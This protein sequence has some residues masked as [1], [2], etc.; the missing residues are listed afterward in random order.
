MK[1]NKI[2]FAALASTMI[3]GCADED[4]MVNGNGS[5]Q[6]LNGKLVEAGLLSGVRDSEESSTR[7]Y[8][9]RGQFVWMPTELEDNG[10][11]TEARKNQKVGFCWTGNNSVHPEYAVTGNS[12]YVYTN[13]EYEHVGWLDVKAD[14][15]DDEECF[16]NELRNGAY[17]VG[18][19]SPEATWAESAPATFYNNYYTQGYPGTA[20]DP[21]GAY[22]QTTHA[23]SSGVLNLASGIFSTK[24]ASVFEGEYLV[25]YPY[26][27]AFTKG[28][29]VAQMP[30]EYDIVIEN[31]KDN[32]AGKYLQNPYAS[33]SDV[34]FAIGYLPHYEGGNTSSS[35]KA[36]TLNALVG[37]KIGSWDASDKTKQGA[38]VKIKTVML[39]SE[40]QGIMYQQNLNAG[41][42]I[43][44]LKNGKGVSAELFCGEPTKTNVIYAN[45]NSDTNE[46]ANE[47]NPVTVEGTKGVPAEY[48]TVAFPVFAQTVSDLQII[49]VN[50]KDQT[51]TVN[52]DAT[53]F[54]A[55]KAYMKTINL[56]GVKFQNEYMVVDEASLWSA[57][58]KIG[59]DGNSDLQAVNKIK[60]LNDITLEGLGKVSGKGNY[61]SWFFDKNINIYSKTTPI[62]TLTLA[63][64]QKMSIKGW[65]EASVNGEATLSFDVPV[66]IQGAGC[67]EKTPAVLVVG[68]ANEKDGK[69]VFNKD[70]TNY[71]TLALNN[72]GTNAQTIEI[73]GILTNK[74]DDY[75]V[76]KQKT[77]GAAEVYMMGAKDA[78]LVIGQFDNKNGKTIVAAT[79]VNLD[80]LFGEEAALPAILDAETATERENFVEIFT[81]NNDAEF[82]IHT[83]SMV[84]IGESFANSTDAVLK[85]Q[86]IAKSK[87]DGRIDIL[88]AAVNAG[89]I[90]NQGVSNLMT[91]LTNTGLFV[92]R[93]SGQV[94][95]KMI[96]NGTSEA[97]AEKKYGNMTYKTDIK[98][99]GIYVAQVETTDRM[100]KILSDK[101]IEPSVNIVEIV[102][103][104][105]V[106]YNMYQ[107]AD[108]MGDKDLLINYET[109][110]IKSYNTTDKKSQLRDLAHC[111]TVLDGCTLKV[112]DG[113]LIV[114]NN[115]NVEKDAVVLFAAANQADKSNIIVQGNINNDGTVTNNATYFEVKKNIENKGTFKSTTQFKV[116]KDV[117]NTGQFISKGDANLISGN[118]NQTGTSSYSEFASK[119]T[120]T[121][122]DTFTCTGGLFERL[123]V[124]GEEHRATVNVNT[125]GSVVG[126]KTTT[127]WPTEY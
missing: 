50:E 124:G 60:M 122:E 62:S 77:T 115:V 74:Y 49:L 4:F 126:G 53:I 52:A 107:Y 106:Y 55:N 47:Q 2:L 63:S 14:N 104:D 27:D 86:G 51:Y 94:G 99:A 108:A 71:G 45:L 24:N 59:S 88:G 113:R 69:V 70:V 85:T 35:F 42:C 37:V 117:N 118:F 9:S 5:A 40:T 97:G 41:K 93:Q 91:Q 1:K 110:V 3:V 11:L 34:A 111:V 90:D 13:Y 79:S 73:N 21:Q 112:F 72:N 10:A 48:V 100:N 16:D 31:D 33:A 127:A 105:V 44:A 114:K 26:T 119:T 8:T 12:S 66:V 19:G 38:D 18:E 109:I 30:T 82:D 46:Q 78:K 123:T 58:E 6:G 96:D 32:T 81:L 67:C 65:R 75:A 17:I 80:K 68:N 15:P 29:I 125:L 61:N 84:T 23:Q 28:E 102:G 92:D 54:E 103:N 98:N 43:D 121:I 22:D 83:M 89:V 87:T 101:V 57:W 56:N 36:K 20:K 25:Y 39:Y 95:G 120:T 76:S 7:A 64:E 116:V